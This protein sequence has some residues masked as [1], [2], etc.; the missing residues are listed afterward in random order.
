MAKNDDLF[1]NMGM[2]DLSYLL[3]TPVSPPATGESTQKKKEEEV[4]KIPLEL[5]DGFKDHPFRVNKDDEEFWQLVDSIKENG[6]IYPLL[7]RP[8]GNRYELIAGHR[9]DAACEAAGLTEAPAIIKEMDDYTATILMV[10]SNLSREK[11]LVSEKAKAY[12]MCMEAEKHQGKKGMD[13]ATMVGK[14]HD[15]R[16]QVYRY[17]RLS[18][19]NEDFLELLDAGKL[20]VNV[21]VEL[22]YINEESQPVLMGIMKEYHISPNI[23]QAGALHKKVDEQGDLS[24]EAMVAI[25]VSTLKKKPASSVSFKKKDLRE[26]FDEDAE[27]EYI[28]E[29]IIKLLQKYKNG[30]VEGLD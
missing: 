14:E 5:I 22:S 4:V 6:L 2:T 24:Y 27:P 11:I 19:L 13:T 26:F 10:H 15:S 16:R 9:R 29:I 1:S 28:H 21:G 12:R 25:L 23:E 18:Y 30:E 8:K 7:L 20:P 17:V 3:E